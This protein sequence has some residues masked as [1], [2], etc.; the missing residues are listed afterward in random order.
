MFRSP[1]QIITVLLCLGIF[2]LISVRAQTFSENIA[3]PRVGI[4]H[5][6][7]RT[8][9]HAKSLVAPQVRSVRL[10]NSIPIQITAGRFFNCA[11]LSNG[12]VKCWG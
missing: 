7:T 12:N 6:G 10:G 2:G 11:L 3:A 5:V 4:S 8:Q 1:L 9:M